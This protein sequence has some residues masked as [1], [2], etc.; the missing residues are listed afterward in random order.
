M[1]FRK[2]FW[3]LGRCCLSHYTRCEMYHSGKLHTFSLVKTSVLHVTATYYD[4]YCCVELGT[5]FT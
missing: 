1:I 2:T 5:A 3:H 4:K